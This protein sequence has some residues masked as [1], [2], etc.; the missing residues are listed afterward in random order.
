MCV[1]IYGQES[2]QTSASSWGLRA[3]LGQCVL[4]GGRVGGKALGGCSRE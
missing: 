2:G 1:L 3:G 4:E